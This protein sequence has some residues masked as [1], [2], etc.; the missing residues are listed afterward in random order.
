MKRRIAIETCHKCLEAGHIAINCT[1]PDR[2]MG[3]YRCGNLGHV[4]KCKEEKEKCFAC[5]TS[6]HRT[7]PTRFPVFR[8]LLKEKKAAKGPRRINHKNDPNTTG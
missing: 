6:E 1:G 2:S 4:A 7:N 8:R 3:C 5:N